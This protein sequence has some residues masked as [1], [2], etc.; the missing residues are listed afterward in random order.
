MQDQNEPPGPYVPAELTPEEK[1]KWTTA[2]D[3]LPYRFPEVWAL[4]ARDPENP[5]N[6]DTLKEMHSWCEDVQ[7]EDTY[8]HD[9]T[10]PETH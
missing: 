2:P 1:E 9:G 7:I 3:G 10:I 8:I 5:W 6:T 4:S